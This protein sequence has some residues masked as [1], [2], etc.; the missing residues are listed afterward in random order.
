M[1]GQT[2]FEILCQHFDPE[3]V[4]LCADLGWIYR[5][6]V[7]PVTFLKQYAPQI[8]YVHLRDFQ[9]SESVPLGKG[10]IDIASQIAYLPQLPNLRYVAIEQDP[11]TSTSIQDMGR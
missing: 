6:G 8:G 5:A 4:S 7:D 11:T 1:R 2:G 9:G 10:D 3:A